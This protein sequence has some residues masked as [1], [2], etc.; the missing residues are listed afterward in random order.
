MMILNYPSKK[1]L[2]ENIGQS[3]NYTETSVFGNEYKS[4]GQFVGC[5]RPTI[6]NNKGREVFASVTMKDD[7]IEAVS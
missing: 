4:D 3:L 6:T 5:N 2:K 1:V 7:K